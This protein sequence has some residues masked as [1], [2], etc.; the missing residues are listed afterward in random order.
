MIEQIANYWL[1]WILGIAAAGI[2]AFARYIWVLYKK[3]QAH[4]KSDEQK[5]ICDIISASLKSFQEKI[6]QDIATTQ[7]NI[8][9]QINVFNSQ[10]ETVNDRISKTN[11]SYEAL[12]DGILSVQGKVFEE[13]CEHFLSKDVEISPDDFEQLTDDF[14]TYKALGGNHKRETLYNFVKRKFEYQIA[15]QIEKQGDF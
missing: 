2:A 5:E 6:Q 12:K 3:E 9:N 8:Q 10:I 14:V 4:R 15:G 1:N 13:K 7:E 11:D